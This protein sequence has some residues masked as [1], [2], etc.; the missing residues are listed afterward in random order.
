[1][2]VMCSKGNVGKLCGSTA[3][4][5]AKTQLEVLSNLSDPLIKANQLIDPENIS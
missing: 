3:L 5:E 4:F 2:D 1:M